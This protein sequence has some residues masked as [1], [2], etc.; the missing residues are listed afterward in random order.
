MIPSVQA[1]YSGCGEA[2]TGGKASP[3]TVRKGL[4]SFSRRHGLYL[5]S[6]RDSLSSCRRDCLSSYRR[7][8]LASYSIVG[9]IYNWTFIN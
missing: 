3:H 6:R 7:N 5:C 1:F 2:A 4:A 9:K 8:G